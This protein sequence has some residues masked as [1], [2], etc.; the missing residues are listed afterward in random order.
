MDAGE[1]AAEALVDDP[2][3]QHR[4]RRQ[5]MVNWNAQHVR[6]RRGER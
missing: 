6:E 5:P 4:I 1:I 3:L 2:E